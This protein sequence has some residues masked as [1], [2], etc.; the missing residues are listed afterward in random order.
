MLIAS[1]LQ[2]GMTM[3]AALPSAGQIA[4]NSHADDRR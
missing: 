2:R 4:P 1:L 3:P